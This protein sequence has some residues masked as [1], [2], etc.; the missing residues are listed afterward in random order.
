M[1]SVPYGW[2]YDDYGVPHAVEAEQQVLRDIHAWNKLGIDYGTIAAMLVARRVPVPHKGKWT[3]N[4]VKHFLVRHEPGV[5]PKELDSSRAQAKRYRKS[6]I[7]YMDAN[8]NVVEL[9]KPGNTE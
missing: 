8:G 2:E 6:A 1:A 4:V 3:V 5:A 7:I 9:R